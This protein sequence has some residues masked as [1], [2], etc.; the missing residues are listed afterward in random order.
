MMRVYERAAVLGMVWG[1]WLVAGSPAAAQGVTVD[2]ILGYKPTQADVV[3]DVPAAAD[4]PKCKVEVERANGKGSGWIVYG[5]DGQTLRRFVDSD[6]DNVVDQW[7]YYQHGLEVY[8]DID[9]NANND[10]DQSRWLNLGGSR[11]GVDANEDGKIERWLRLSAEEASRE[12]IHAMANRDVA[13]LTAVLLDAQDIRA[14][15]LQDAVGREAQQA[16]ANPAAQMQQILTKSKSLTA[17]TRW[18]RFDSSLLMPNLI[19][20]EA[21]KAERDLVVY[22]NVMAIVE[23]AGQPAFV[24]IG[25]MVQVGDVWKLTSIPQP[26]EG[27]TQVVAGGL[28]MQPSVASLT[29]GTVQLSAEMQSLI[30]QLQKLDEAAPGAEAKPEEAVRY[31][32]SRAGLLGKL[33]AA[34]GTAEDQEVWQRQRVEGIAAAVQMNA[35]PDGLAELRKLEQDLRTA[36]PQSP[37]LPYVVICRLAADYNVQLQAA[38]TDGRQAVQDQWVKSLEAFIQEFPKSTDAGDALLQ[39]GVSQEFVGEVD[40]AKEWYRQLLQGHRG[41]AA[42]NR[43]AGALRRLELVGQPL[44]LTGPAL[45]GGTVDIKQYKGKVVAVIFWATWCKPC[46]EELPQLLELYRQNKPQGFEV[47]GVN[48]DSPDAPVQ[49]FIQQFKVPWPHLAEEGGLESRPA[50]EFGIITVPTMFLVDRQ[51]KVVSSNASIEVLKEQVPELLKP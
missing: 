38:N 25:E 35:Y 21:G 37:L 31:N 33:A 20:Q 17:G 19:P 41:T 27:D 51:G 18:T 47:I 48:L 5:P 23:N 10:V 9:T 7:R 24:Q 34:A 3:Y 22:E 8:R 12:A 30:E 28:L 46:V 4:I 39:L 13:A 16:V 36:S 1:L 49:Q 43:G 6:G 40:K 29:E 45:G 2:Q 50:Q 32:T 44:T 42:A 15:G 14:L 26:L 11:W